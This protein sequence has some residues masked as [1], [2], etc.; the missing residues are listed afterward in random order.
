MNSEKISDSSSLCLACG[1]CC[2]GTLIGFVQLGS[3]ELPALRELME[4]EEQNGEGFFLHPC[5]RFCDGCTIY[6]DRPKQCAS[7]KCGLLKSLEAKE[8]DCD[9]AVE[10][11]KVVKQKR[12][13]I[14]EKLMTQPY[15]LK[16]DSFYF[17]MVELKKLL[18]KDTSESP[19]TEDLK[20]LDSLLL[21]NFGISLD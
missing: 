3:E 7:F 14:E 13:A 18:K 2:D 1:C 5:D 6:S 21:K 4:V 12:I 11:I 15:Q 8:T 17:K 16:S 19:L 20:Q 10:V 9:S